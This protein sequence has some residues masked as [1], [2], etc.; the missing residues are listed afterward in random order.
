MPKALP[1]QHNAWARRWLDFID[2]VGSPSPQRMSRARTYVRNG[3]VWR[4]T[5]APGALS[6]Q[7]L[8]SYGYY[9]TSILLPI[10]AAS[11]WDA[12]ITCLAN[13]P[14]LVASL[15]AGELSEE[16]VGALQ[17][18]GV[19]LF[20]PVDGGITWKCTCPDW[21]RPCKHGLAVA[22]AFAESLD[23]QPWLLLN[24]R[25]HAIESI[26]AHIQQ[27]WASANSDESAAA[28]NEHATIQT[29]LTADGFYHAGPALDDFS[30]SLQATEGG[31]ALLLSAGKPPFTPDNEE[32]FRLLAEAYPQMTEQALRM[33]SGGK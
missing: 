21:E 17:S 31:A 32:P 6:A 25:G 7:V 28:P 2:I 11:D 12:A 15:L 24:L 8:G 22:Q 14:P 9:T 5:V 16:L 10:I 18:V 30:I 27:R 3:H 29:A 20:P 23:T 13:D 33:L 4:L 26:V 1:P 19:S